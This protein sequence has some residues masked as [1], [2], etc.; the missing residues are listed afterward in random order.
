M[1]LKRICNC[2]YRRVTRR[3]P[4]FE[5]VR[6]PTIHR[7]RGARFEF[8]AKARPIASRGAQ[9]RPNFLVLAPAA[10]RATKTA[11]NQSVSK[12]YRRA[13]F[14]ERPRGRVALELAVEVGAE[15]VGGTRE[16]DI[17][18]LPGA[19]AEVVRGGPAAVAH[20]GVRT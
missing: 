13:G 2:Y 20:G 3:R 11:I 16:K 12:G 14:L 7:G 6:F 4:T 17:V 5:F 15:V 1:N 9:P 8:N 10:G 18:G 19:A